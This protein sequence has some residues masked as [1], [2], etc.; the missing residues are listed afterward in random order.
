MGTLSNGGNDG[1]T[2]MPTSGRVTCGSMFLTNTD[3]VRRSV[4]KAAA[5]ALLM[6]SGIRVTPKA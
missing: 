2:S 6:I 3:E 1:S 5:F 4:K